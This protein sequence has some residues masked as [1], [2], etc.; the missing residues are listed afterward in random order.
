MPNKIIIGFSPQTSPWRQLQE[1]ILVTVGSVDWSAERALQ[2][3]SITIQPLMG[4]AGT[5]AM[6][7]MYV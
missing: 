2:R 4:M 1:L 6:D 3:I 5:N 7:S